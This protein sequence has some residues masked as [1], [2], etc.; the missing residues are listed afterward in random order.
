MMERNNAD[1]KPQWGRR[2][3]LAAVLLALVLMLTWLFHGPLNV[4]G[5]IAPW[6]LYSAAALFLLN[7]ILEIWAAKEQS[8][9]ARLE[10]SLSGVAVAA[11][12]V[13]LQ[14]IWE[15]RRDW[16]STGHTIGL[17]LLM[18]GFGLTTLRLLDEHWLSKGIIRLKQ[19]RNR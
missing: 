7:T 14:L 2:V 19:A 4:P 10:L 13:G 3:G 18:L 8:G 6:L 12:L 1:V 17:A 9:L 5:D 16:E 11:Y 15:W